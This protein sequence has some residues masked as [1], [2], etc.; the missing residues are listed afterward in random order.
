MAIFARFDGVDGESH[1]AHHMGW[2]DVEAL[3]WGVHRPDAAAGSS[4]RRGAAVVENMGLLFGYEKAAPKLL[5]RCLK[6]TVTPVV[7]VEVTATFGGARQTY[8][9]Y[10]MKN[11]LVSSYQVGAD[12]NDEAGP[13]AVSVEVGFD[14]VTVTYIEF[15]DTGASQGSTETTWKVEPAERANTKKSKNGKK[16]KSKKGKKK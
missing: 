16:R 8:L 9:R 4:R 6:G 1:D 5:E 2:I 11:V 3:E 13:P 14:E 10:E 15:D 12:G 7:E